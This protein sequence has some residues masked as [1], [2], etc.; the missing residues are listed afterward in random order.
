MFSLSVAHVVQNCACPCNALATNE[1]ILISK[2]H[3]EL[4]LDRKIKTCC[5]NVL[6][7]PFC[8]PCCATARQHIRL[9]NVYDFHLGSPVPPSAE[10]V[11]DASFYK[12]PPP[13]Y[14]VFLN[15]FFCYACVLRKNEAHLRYLEEKGLIKYEWE[16]SYN[17]ARSAR[18]FDSSSRDPVKTFAILGVPQSGKTTLYS[19]LLNKGLPEHDEV[20]S[21]TKS[22]NYGCKTLFVQDGEDSSKPV[23]FNFYDAPADTQA[24]SIEAASSIALEEADG[25]LLVFD[26]TSRSSFLA[27]E[28]AFQEL[29]LRAREDEKPLSPVILVG[30]FLDVAA[31][32]CAFEKDVL[33]FVKR[34]KKS[35]SF[36]SCSARTGEGVLDITM[37]GLEMLLGVEGKEEMERS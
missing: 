21:S 20:A 30:N 22:A 16:P 33:R 23:F 6:L 19:R 9:Q 35:V 34:H 2:S 25:V 4:V 11:D 31:G 24:E 1:G 17:E 3:P 10:I 15:A 36:V 29:Q 37:K 14:L 5:L 26:R 32:K 8:G 7:T 27:V 12:P 18:G 28:N 13:P